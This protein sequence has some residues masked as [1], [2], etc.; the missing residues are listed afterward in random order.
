[1]SMYHKYKMHYL[2]FLITEIYVQHDQFLEK[3][4]IWFKLPNRFSLEEE[5][6]VV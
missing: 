5:R 3:I 1:M 2:N 4:W 6:S